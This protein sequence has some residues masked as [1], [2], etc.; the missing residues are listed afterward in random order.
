MKPE[1]PINFTISSFYTSFWRQKPEVASK[2]TIFNFR[3]RIFGQ[4][5]IYN[6]NF[7]TGSSL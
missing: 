4:I 1:V 3:T 5:Q 7:E 2:V 6:L